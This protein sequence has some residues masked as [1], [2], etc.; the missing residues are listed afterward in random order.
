MHVRD[1]DECVPVRDGGAPHG[2]ANPLFALRHFWFRR[3]EPSGLPF[4]SPLLTMA[5]AQVDPQQRRRPREE[6]P[7]GRQTRQKLDDQ[8]ARL[9]GI[10]AQ[11]RAHSTRLSYL[12]APYK[13]VLRGWPCVV[14]FCREIRTSEYRAVK[15]VF[16]ASYFTDLREHCGPEA[17]AL[18]DEAD[19]LFAERMGYALIRVYPTGGSRDDTP[20]GVIRQQPGWL[21]DRVS[22][23]L[24]SAAR[25]LHDSRQMFQ[26]RVERDKRKGKGK[27]K[28]QVEEGG[29]KGK[30]K[31]KRKGRGPPRGQ[32]PHD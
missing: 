29:R 30:G 22:F 16:I 11:L 21:G 28:G 9:D 2:L 31:D 15:T 17:G 14:D 18:I 6:R 5:D 4:L 32:Q 20:D 10:E 24:S 27:G 7:I 13:V 8:E 25:C 12:E 1:H 19:N 26:G 3:L 23:L